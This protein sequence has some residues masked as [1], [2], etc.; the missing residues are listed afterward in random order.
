MLMCEAKDS[1]AQG[2]CSSMVKL[3]RVSI[4]VEKKAFMIF[5]RGM[6]M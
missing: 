6:G 3:S 5:F 1:W 4:F 2:I